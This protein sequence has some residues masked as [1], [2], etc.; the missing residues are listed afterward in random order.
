MRSKLLPNAVSEGEP[1]NKQILAFINLLSTTYL[2]KTNR[3][4]YDPDGDLSTT[5]GN[6]LAETVLQIFAQDVGNVIWNDQPGSRAPD[7]PIVEDFHAHAKG[8]PL[9]LFLECTPSSSCVKGFQGFCHM[10]PSKQS[11]QSSAG[12]IG[13]DESGGFYLMHSTPNFPD[14]PAD[15]EYQGKRPIQHHAIIAS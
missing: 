8:E 4:T 11:F 5:S 13:F 12:V 15:S 2:L 7:T 1:L 3:F 6:P 14:N 9:S 10:S